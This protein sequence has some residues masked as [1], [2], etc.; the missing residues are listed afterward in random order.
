MRRLVPFLT[1]LLLPA[2]G[3]GGSTF[4]SVEPFAR[5]IEGGNSKLAVTLADGSSVFVMESGGSGLVF[6]NP[7]SGESQ[8]LGSTAAMACVAPNGELLWDRAPPSGSYT[9]ESLHAAPGGTFWLLGN[10]R[11]SLS[12]EGHM[13]D[14][15]GY[16]RMIFAVR[17]DAS[18]NVIDVR[19]L[20]LGDDLTRPVFTLGADGSSALALTI[21]GA[22]V[23]NPNAADRMATSNTPDD[24]TVLRFD[25]AGSILW[26]RHVQSDGHDVTA[27]AMCLR[28]DGDLVFHMHYQF[29][30]TTILWITDS[31]DSPRLDADSGLVQLDANGAVVHVYES[32][33]ADWTVRAIAPHLDG[34]VLCGIYLGTL[35]DANGEGNDLETQGNPGYVMRCGEDG[36]PQWTVLQDPDDPD[37]RAA[38]FSV[39][40]DAAGRILLA[41]EVEGSAV[42]ESKT[43][44]TGI[45]SFGPSDNGV[46]MILDEHG[47]HLRLDTIRAMSWSSAGPAAFLPNGDIAIA[48]EAV[49]S[50]NIKGTPI[51]VELT[52]DAIFLI[53]LTTS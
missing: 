24:L 9:I 45:G 52:G 30:S 6:S 31:N 1:L 12:F 23:F 49:D 40:T 10:S 2:C 13:L 48:G 51:D 4:E 14:A 26:L 32:P 37:D 18:G 44:D 5:L 53:R 47:N 42:F 20:A 34:H 38:F 46:V 25:S 29:G 27:T 22:S 8:P 50:I 7:D 17:F 15:E 36:R 11:G 43:Q 21:S 16:G 35:V 33:T 19:V 41:G 3:G 39:D 28:P